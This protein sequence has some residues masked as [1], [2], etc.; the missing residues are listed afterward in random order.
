[1]TALPME[2]GTIFLSGPITI[3]RVESLTE[4]LRNR[5]AEPSLDSLRLDLSKVTDVDTAGLQIFLA[6]KRMAEQA[7]KTLELLAVNATVRARFRLTGLE[8]LCNR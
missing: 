4:A 5:V 7:G 6:T 2:N 8:F 1:M 3:D